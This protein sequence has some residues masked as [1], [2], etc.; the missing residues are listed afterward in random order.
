[1][2]ESYREMEARHEALDD[3]MYRQEYADRWAGRG[4]GPT[5]T[6][7]EPATIRDC[8]NCR[9]AKGE[10]LHEC[11]VLDNVTFNRAGRCWSWDPKDE[12][13]I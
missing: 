8:T 1:M 3:Q 11:Q 5:I 9:Y 7:P 2:T 10:F 13:A 12:V 4:E 6:E